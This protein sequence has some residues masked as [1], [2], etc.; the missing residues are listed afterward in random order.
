MQSGQT[1]QQQKHTFNLVTFVLIS[2]LYTM[3]CLVL[4]IVLDRTD[5]TQMLIAT[6]AS[7]VWTSSC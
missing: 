2:H 6:T 3:T 4:F 7:S 5:V 1:T